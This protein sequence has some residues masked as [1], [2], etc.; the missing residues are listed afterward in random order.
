MAQTKKKRKT[1]H[2]GTQGGQIESKGRTSRPRSAKQ[3]RQQALQQKQ[4]KRLERAVQPPSWRGATIR[5]GFAAG[6]F[7][8]VLVFMKQPFASSIIIGALMFGLYIP[9]GYYMDRFLYDRRLK[10]EARQREKG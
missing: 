4:N 9:M 3:A 1:K 6:V 7:L 2:R 5:A 8:V 10:R